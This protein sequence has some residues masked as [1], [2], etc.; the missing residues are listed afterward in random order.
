LADIATRISN[1]A[2]V[3]LLGQWVP[4]SGGQQRSE[5][6]V[7]KVLMVGDGDT[8][9]GQPILLDLTFLSDHRYQGKSDSKKGHD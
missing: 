7:E 3:S 6:Q 2:F 5:M 4:S 1:G 9:V 8:F